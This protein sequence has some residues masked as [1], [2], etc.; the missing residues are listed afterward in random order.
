MWRSGTGTTTS[1][2]PPPSVSDINGAITFATT[3]EVAPFE[4]VH[5]LLP[6]LLVPQGSL[7]AVE[8]EVLVPALVAPED[9]EGRRCPT[10]PAEGSPHKRQDL[11]ARPA[12]EVA[13]PPR[14]AYAIIALHTGVAAEKKGLP[15]RLGE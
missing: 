2:R 8:G 3:R 7:R 15:R 5:G 14:A 4:S 13:H 9:L 11:E 1:N 6:H 10:P 12:E